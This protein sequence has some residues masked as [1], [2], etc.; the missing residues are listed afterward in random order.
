VEA[1]KHQDVVSDRVTRTLAERIAV[2][3][4][5]A[6]LGLY[7]AP[8][9]ANFGW[10]HLGAERDEQLV[11][12]GLAQRGVLVRSGTALGRAGTLRVT[13]GTESENGRFL[14]ALRELL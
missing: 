8:S 11:L 2:G 13:Y 12:D 10:V 7:V 9:Q 6:E 1:L 14:E 4:A 3:E 5:L